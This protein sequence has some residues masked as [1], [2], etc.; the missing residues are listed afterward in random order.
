MEEVKRRKGCRTGCLVVLLLLLLLIGW[1]VAMRWGALEK[2]GLRQPIAEQVFSPPPDR[3]SAS[4]IVES[5]EQAGMNTEGVAV[6]VLPMASG[7]GSVAMVMLDTTQGFDPERLFTNE[8][9]WDALEALLD[10]GSLDDMN[11]TRM[12][13]DYVDQDGESIVTLTATTDALR[14]YARGEIDEQE[15]MREV[16]GRIDIPGLIKEVTP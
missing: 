16:M 11:V 2:L 6:H 5:L 15:L 13:I 4:A 14:D 9:D 1:A 7:E 3:E 12:A 8:G 10:S